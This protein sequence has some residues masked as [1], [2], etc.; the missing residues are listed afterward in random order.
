[1]KALIIRILTLWNTSFTKLLIC[2]IDHTYLS[3]FLKKQMQNICITVLA[4]VF[5]FAFDTALF[6]ETAGYYRSDS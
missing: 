5:G 6:E 1:M 3:F 4:G 2:K